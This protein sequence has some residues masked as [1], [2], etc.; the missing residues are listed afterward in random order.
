MASEDGGQ[1]QA[2]GRIK[3]ADGIYGSPICQSN[4][5]VVNQKQIINTM[6]KVKKES[7][8]PQITLHRK[9][10]IKYHEA[11]NPGMNSGYSGR[12]SSSH[13]T[14]GSCR[15]IYVYNPVTSHAG[16]EKDE[17]V[18]TIYITSLS[19]VIFRTR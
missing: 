11:P 9:L 13:F 18:A 5:I 10:E 19:V 8:K 4:F 16:I 6:I 1:V 15:V 3:P 14:T 7:T 12:I 17:I 2:C